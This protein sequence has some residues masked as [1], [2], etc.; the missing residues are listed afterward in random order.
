MRYFLIEEMA[1]GPN[2]VRDY[3]VEAKD[4][5]EAKR[6]YIRHFGPEGAKFVEAK[7]IADSTT[8]ISEVHKQSDKPFKDLQEYLED[9]ADDFTFDGVLLEHLRI[10][11]GDAYVLV[12][13]KRKLLCG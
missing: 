4:L 8:C 10:G 12:K 7:T 11:K 5:E 6:W 13:Q 9:E 3:L 1:R 2:S